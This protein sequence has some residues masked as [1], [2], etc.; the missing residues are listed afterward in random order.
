MCPS[1]FRLRLGIFGRLPERRGL[2]TCMWVHSLLIYP[3]QAG[4]FDFRIKWHASYEA[5]CSRQQAVT[6]LRQYQKHWSPKCEL[7]YQKD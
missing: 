6:V 3:R 7:E 5:T 1:D 2:G 4:L